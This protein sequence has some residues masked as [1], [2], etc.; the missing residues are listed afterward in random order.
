LRALDWGFRADIGSMIA[1]SIYKC[2]SC[3]ARDGNRVA[4]DKFHRRELP[5]PDNV[6]LIIWKACSG[7][8]CS[9]KS[10]NE[11]APAIKIRHAPQQQQ[12]SPFLMNH[13]FQGQSRG[14]GPILMRA[15]RQIAAT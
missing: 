5:N 12:Q 10:C 14:I 11:H 9:R 15:R 6:M 13:L 7:E 1:I 8:N 3:S 4:G 2:G